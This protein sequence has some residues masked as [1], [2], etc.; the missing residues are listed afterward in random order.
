MINSQSCY[1]ISKDVITRKIEGELVIVPMVE[2]IGDLDSQ[3]FSLNETGTAVW[4]KLD[5]KTNLE[6]IIRELADEYNTPYDQIKTD[7][8]D[9]MQMFEKM[10]LLIEK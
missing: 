10:G 6:N 1:D 8:L 7:V 4:E 5:G 3:M 2:G 9:I